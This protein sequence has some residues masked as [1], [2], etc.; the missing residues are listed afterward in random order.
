MMYILMGK[1]GFLEDLVGFI[2]YTNFF[3]L[4]SV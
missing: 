2:W 4:K 3:Q 1:F